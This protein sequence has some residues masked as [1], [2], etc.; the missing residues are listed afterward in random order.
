MFLRL[1]FDLFFPVYVSLSPFP[2]PAS[3]SPINRINIHPPDA[4]K[5]HSLG[6][7]DEEC[8]GEEEEVSLLALQARLQL[9]LGMTQKLTAWTFDQ[10]GLDEGAR[11]RDDWSH[12]AFPRTQ[13]QDSIDPRSKKLTRRDRYR[14]QYWM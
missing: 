6:L 8:V 10:E 1:V 13:K 3:F 5:G 12:A 7:G 9:R 2:F 11:L 4:P 14:H